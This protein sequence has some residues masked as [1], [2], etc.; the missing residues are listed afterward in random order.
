METDLTTMTDVVLFRSNDVDGL[1]HTNIT[2]ANEV[3]VTVPRHSATTYKWT[4]PGSEYWM[5]QIYNFTNNT[6]G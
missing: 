3:L 6:D 1:H 4:P 5:T 2:D